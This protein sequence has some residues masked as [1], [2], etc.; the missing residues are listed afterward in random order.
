MSFILT[1]VHLGR[2]ACVAFQYSTGA[3]GTKAIYSVRLVV[4]TRLIAG[5]VTRLE[6][7]SNAMVGIEV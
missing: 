4:L 3:L 7:E 5:L 6:R 2:C 1:E